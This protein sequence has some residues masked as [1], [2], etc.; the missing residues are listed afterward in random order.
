MYFELFA[1]IRDYNPSPKCVCGSNKT[2]RDY[3][4]DVSSILGSVK[5]S[6]S[7]LKTVG[8]LANRNRDRMSEDQRVDLHHRH[9][10][11]KEVASQKE[12]PK[13][14]QR[15]TKPKIKTKWTKP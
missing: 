13:G 7:E 12:L 14:M 4:N 5:K 1:H 8:D 2:E 9:N 6:D 3:A 15:I 11:Y 10:D